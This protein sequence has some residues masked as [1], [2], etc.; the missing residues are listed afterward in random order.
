MTRNFD[1]LGELRTNFLNGQFD[2]PDVFTI[3]GVA[4]HISNSTNHTMTQM[5]HE[6]LKGMV[7]YALRRADQNVQLFN[8]RKQE[9]GVEDRVIFLWARTQKMKLVPADVRSTHKGRVGLAPFSEAAQPQGQNVT[10]DRI[11]G[12][13]VKVI[14]S[15]LNGNQPFD[16]KI[17][18]GATLSSLHAENLKVTHGQHDSQPTVEF[19]NGDKRYRMTVVTTQAVKTADGGVENRPVIRLNVKINGNTYN[20]IMFNLNDR[21]GMPE[22]ILLGQNF[23]EKGKFLIDPRIQEDVDWNVLQEEFKDVKAPVEAETNS[24]SIETVVNTL[25]EHK[26]VTLADVVKYIRGRAYTTLKEI[27]Y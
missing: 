21:T 4:Y 13:N 6:N 26:D 17:D 18:T 3:G 27:D 8:Q 24:E 12:T 1:T 20:D 9:L 7:V 16:A 25:L 23:L 22:P 5:F 15:G 19:S 11:I 2:L 14:L 10:D